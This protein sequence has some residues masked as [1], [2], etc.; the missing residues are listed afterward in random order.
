MI[1]VC[2]GDLYNTLFLLHH[3]DTSSCGT[4]CSVNIVM[5]CV[6]QKRISQ[7]GLPTLFHNHHST[8]HQE[9]ISNIAGYM[10]LGVVI[11]WLPWFMLL[12]I[13][14][15]MV[16][17]L[18]TAVP[19]KQFSSLQCMIGLHIFNSQQP[20]LGTQRAL[21]EIS[22]LSTVYIYSYQYIYQ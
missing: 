16:T 7:E 4:S 5:S 9:V 2:S 14:V 6:S 22:Y 19:A 20:V 8:N 3:C 10:R 11:L 13:I 21:T 17:T 18:L 15:V 12:L 1:R